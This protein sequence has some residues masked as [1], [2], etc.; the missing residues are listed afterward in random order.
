M[1]PNRSRH[2]GTGE[3]NKRKGSDANGQ[4]RDA[5]ARTAGGRKAFHHYA[6]RRATANDA[7]VRKEQMTAD[8]PRRAGRKGFISFALVISST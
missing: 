8:L 5:E 6:Q 3:R 1:V 7:T 2:L 4:E